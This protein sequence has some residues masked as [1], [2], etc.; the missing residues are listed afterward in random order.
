MVA[1]LLSPLFRPERMPHDDRQKCHHSHL[2]LVELISVVSG[3]WWVVTM[4]CIE[5]VVGW[6]SS[7]LPANVTCGVWVS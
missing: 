6:Y 3:E 5:V 7:R 4:E 2:P 1:E